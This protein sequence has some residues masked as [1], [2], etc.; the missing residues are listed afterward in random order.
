MKRLLCA[1]RW[2][3]IGFGL[4]LVT[5]FVVHLTLRPNPEL[6]AA[7]QYHVLSAYIEPNLTSESHDLGSRDALVVIDGR[8]TFSEPM[9]NSNKVKQYISLLSS[10]SHAQARIRQLHRSLVF[11]FWAANLR[12]VTFE[13]KFHLTARYELATEQEMNLYPFEAFSAR[14]P[15]SYGAL[16]FSRVAFNRDLTEA[17]FYTENLCGLCGEGKFVYMRKT[18]GKWVVA[19]TSSTWIS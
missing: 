7:E 15:S 18:G 8:T 16:T 6:A 4:G 12:D 11:E 14:F 17:F 1:A 10:T 9:V 5:L 2:L 3:L 13:R 19:D